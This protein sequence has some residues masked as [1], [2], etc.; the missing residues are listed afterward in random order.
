[1]RAQMHLGERMRAAGQ[2]YWAEDRERKAA[3]GPRIMT[4]LTGHRCTRAPAPKLGR[5]QLQTQL[6]AARG[7]AAAC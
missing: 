5:P 7:G 6:P 1:M 4:L 2:G 3:L